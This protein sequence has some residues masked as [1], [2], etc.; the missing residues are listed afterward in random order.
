[1]SE[2]KANL[3]CDFHEPYFGATYPDAC[4]IDGFLWDLDSGEGDGYLSVGGD[5]PCPSCNKAKHDEYFN[6]EDFEEITT[7][8]LI[9]N[10]KEAV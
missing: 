10:E 9:P 6:D 3:G 8:D 1:M 5:V 7:Q 2:I 4:C